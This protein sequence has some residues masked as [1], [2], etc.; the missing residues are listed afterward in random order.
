MEKLHTILKEI[1][2]TDKEIKV[3]LSLLELEHTTVQWIAKKSNLNRTTV[4]DILFSLQQKGLT[5]FYVKEKTR[6]FVAAEPDRLTEILEEK[7]YKEKRVLNQLEKELPGLRALYES[8]KVKPKVEFF[9][10]PRHLEEIY[11]K[12]YG[13]GA[14]PEDCLEYASWSRHFEVYP[15]DTR[16]RLL[17]YRKKHNIFIRQV[18]VKH[19]YTE[20]WIKGDYAKNRFKEIRLI[21]DTGFDFG[22]NIE[23]YNNY[24]VITIFNKETG[25]TGLMIESYELTKMIR[26][27]FEYMW[28]AAK[29][30]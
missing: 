25:L 12:M 10:N 3:Y 30:K 22:G 29:S 20:K 14:S 11:L 7:I 2:L 21:K 18:A 8:K 24:V 16:E 17:N 1:G 6:Y 19:P 28:R 5:R 15:K 23:T 26:T 4:Y 9:D 27:M 13:K